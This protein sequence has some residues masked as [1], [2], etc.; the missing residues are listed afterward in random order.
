MYNVGVLGYGGDG[1]IDLHRGH[2]SALGYHDTTFER[3]PI[4]S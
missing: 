4:L 2:C 1:T 3:L